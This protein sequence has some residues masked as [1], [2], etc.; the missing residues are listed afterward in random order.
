MKESMSGGQSRPNGFG[1]NVY[2]ILEQT[3]DRETERWEFGPGDEVVGEL[4]E[5]SD[6]RIL[7]ATRSPD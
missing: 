5:S 2:R 6:N 7:A 1:E 4:I 3:H